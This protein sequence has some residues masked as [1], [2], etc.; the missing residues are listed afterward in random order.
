MRYVAWGPVRGSTGCLHRSIESAKAACE[1]D[2]K[3]CAKVG[4][5]SD[6]RVWEVDVKAGE[7]LQNVTEAYKYAPDSIH[8]VG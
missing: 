5:Y 2:Q 1:R 3:R 6:R 8:P 7:T 4:G